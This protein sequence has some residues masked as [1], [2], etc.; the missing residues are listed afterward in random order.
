MLSWEFLPHIVGGLGAHVSALAPALARQGVQVTIVTPRWNGGAPVEQVSSNLVVYRIDPPVQRMGNFFADV[1]Q[2]NLNLEEVAHS[3]WGSADAEGVNLGFDLIHAHDW[4]VG[5]AAEALKRLHKRPLIATI[6]ATER[7]RG[8][9]ELRGEMAVS[10]DGVEWWLTYE[11][12]RIITAS[13]FMAQE[14]KNYFRVPPDKVVVVP[15]GV[16]TEPFDVL[17][18][19]DLT[20]FR[21]QWALPEDKVIFYVGRIQAEKGVHLLV[22]AAPPILSKHPATKFILAGTGGLLDQL[23]LRALELNVA[24]R[25]SL[26]GYVSDSTRD[27]LYKTSTAAVFPSLYEPFGIVALEAMA[28]E[29]PVIVSDVGGLREVVQNGVTGTVVVPDHVDSLVHGIINT[30]DRPDLARIRSGN[31]YRLV[32]RE[33]TWDHIAAHTIR[34]YET[35]IGGS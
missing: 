2:T 8:R 27:R 35:A 26:P 33:Y 19:V 5:F 6:H 18:G 31:A 11:S 4:L 25:V 28:A 22:E 24:E 17:D 1:Q 23:R 12:V 30:L 7:G 32:K 10:I 15:N 16:N 3:I 9:G 20:E 21:A 13:T 14:V 34:E 29:C